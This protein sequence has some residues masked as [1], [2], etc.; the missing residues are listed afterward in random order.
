MKPLRR[1]VLLL[2]SLQIGYS[3]G[4][5]ALVALFPIGTGSNGWVGP[6][7]S[8]NGALSFIVIA[9]KRHPDGFDKTYLHQLA[10]WATLA[11]VLLGVLFGGLALFVFVAT[12]TALPPHWGWYVLAGV[13]GI[14]L[15]Y[16][17]TRFGFRTG[18]RLVDRPKASAKAA[19]G[20][21]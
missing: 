19:P 3:A 12:G 8:I 11:Q 9:S 16:L 2:L 6:V 5:A 4:L 20:G 21:G 14:P 15:A 18:I 13:L 17:F 7:G 10:M 1:D